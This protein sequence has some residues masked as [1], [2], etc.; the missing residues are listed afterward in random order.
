MRK[1]LLFGWMLQVS[2]CSFA[3][4][5]LK[6]IGVDEGPKTSG[7]VINEIQASNVDMFVDPS[8]NYGGW[9]ELYNP[10]SSPIDLSRCFISD[11]A[12]NLKKWA[13]EK[14]VGMIPAKGFATLWFDHHS[15]YAES[16]IG[17]E[18]ESKGAT[19]YI[20]DADGTI[21]TQQKYPKAMSRTSYARTT[22]GGTKWAVTAMPTP[23]RTNATSIFAEKRVK[24]PEVSVS[25]QRINGPISFDVKIPQNTTLRYTTD[26]SAPTWTHGETSTDGH[27]TVSDAAVFRFCLFQEGKLPSHV[28]TRS[29]FKD[30]K[31]NLLPILSVV[32]APENLYGDSLGVFVTGVNGKPGNGSVEPRNWNMDWDR[33]VS[34]ELISRDNKSLFRQETNLS[35]CGG[36]S[37]SNVPHSFKLKANNIY[38][39]ENTLDYPFFS[40]KPFIRNKTLQM[41]SGGNDSFGRFKDPALQTIVLSSGLYIDGQSYEPVLTYVNGKYNGVMNIREP[42]NKHYS[43]ANYGLSSDEQDQF[44]M[45]G[46][47]GYQQ[48][49]GTDDSFKLWRQ[50]AERCTEDSVYERITKMVDIDEYCNYWASLLYLEPL[51]WGHN[52]IK[53]FRGKAEGSKW[54]HVMF[55]LDSAF[56]GDMNKML[57]TVERY[58]TAVE[59]P[60]SVVVRELA[61]TIIFRNMLKNAT[62]RK[63]FIDAFCIVSG[64]VFEPSRCTHIVDS[65]LNNVKEAMFAEGISPLGSAGTIKNKLT[66]ERQAA[67]I[68]KLKAHPLMELNGVEA[69]QLNLSTNLPE[70]RLLINDQPVPTNSFRGALFSPIQIKAVAPAGYRFMGWKNVQPNSSNLIQKESNW[71]FYD[72]GS[73]DDQNWKSPNYNSA[74][75]KQGRAPLGFSKTG[76]GFNTQISYGADAANKIPTY[77]FRKTITLPARP[78]PT[79]VFNFNFNVDDGCVIYLNGVEVGRHNMNPGTPTYTDFASTFAD[80]YDRAT[81]TIS[82]ELFKA[83]KNV[84][85]VEVHNVSAPSSDIYW[86]ASL[87]LKSSATDNDYVSTNPVYELP[88]EGNYEL[89]ASFEPLNAE[90]LAYTENRPVKVNEISASNSVFVNEY[91]KKDD[92]IELY[93][94]TD[95]PLDV[96][97]MYLTNDFRNPELFR[98]SGGDSINTVIPPHGHL[99]VWASKRIQ[100]KQLHANFK[101]AAEKGYVMLTSADRTWS[102]TLTY[103]LHNGDQSIGLYPDGGTQAYLMDKPTIGAANIYTMYA[104][105]YADDKNSLVTSLPSLI[106]RMGGLSIAFDGQALTLKSEY[107]TH[108]RLEI[109]NASGQK[110]SSKTVQ[111]P[112]GFSQES[113]NN[114]PVGIYVARLS[115]NDGNYCSVKFIR[116]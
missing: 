40:A 84:I 18:L 37:R 27:F 53:G 12:T 93:N 69:E 65:L 66:A 47:L 74:S 36:W 54:H 68:A 94:T 97:G 45:D 114:L 58:Y 32:S 73:L 110:I 104:E 31:Q 19:L 43:F 67:M 102:D 9:I 111:L 30:N 33:P 28:V 116:K 49:A 87:E 23:G 89:V 85:A 17:F 113:V 109:F 4:Q 88:A 52:N 21:I 48:M 80:E 82:P 92:W 29:F 8:F 101:L 55:D 72:K 59:R 79:D 105:P 22:D 39:G 95:E 70:A 15:Q 14:S 115:D 44:E 63:H 38:D 11:D 61:P 90:D 41:R 56:D 60:G 99:V 16:Q 64:S 103:K 34:M 25:S 75:W 106:S 76:A 81:I 91:G 86:D 96:E 42:N 1:F 51:D 71:D 78:M 83:G 98:I 108:C 20:S 24:K 7:I 26:G 2:M 10:T 50:L 46:S 112:E 6:K 100:K 3:V 35:I 77:Y 13:L 57:N 107:D 5:N 62:F